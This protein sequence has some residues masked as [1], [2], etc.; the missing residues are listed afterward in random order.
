MRP[1]SLPDFVAYIE[2]SW[3]H[4]DEKGAKRVMIKHDFEFLQ[5]LHGMY[6]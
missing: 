1:S 6:M 4:L 5:K 2:G 3:Q